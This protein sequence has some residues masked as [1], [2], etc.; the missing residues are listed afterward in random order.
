M[1][2]FGKKQETE[3]FKEQCQHCGGT[4]LQ[5]EDEIETF[6][7]SCRLEDLN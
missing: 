5:G 1:F 3:L 7:P 6:C 4:F 2:G